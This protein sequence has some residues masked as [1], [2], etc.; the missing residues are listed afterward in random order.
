MKNLNTS[1]LT[2]A[3]IDAFM[4]AQ[5]LGAI[6]FSDGSDSPDTDEE[7]SRAEADLHARTL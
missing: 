1:D 2:E 5:A 3:E 6:T 4:I 7:W